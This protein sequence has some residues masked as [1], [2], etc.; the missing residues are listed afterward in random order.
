MVELFSV[1]YKPDYRLV[2]KSEE[3]ELW[4][5]VKNTK[6]EERILPDK[7]PFPPLLAVS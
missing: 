3:A 1:S 7:G 4:E 2:P 6:I 5:R